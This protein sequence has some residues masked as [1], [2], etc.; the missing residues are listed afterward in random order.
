MIAAL[1]C[2]K[3]SADEGMWMIHMIDSALEKKMQERGL[4]LSARE[5]YNAD[6]PGASLSDAVVSME[7][8]CSGSFISDQGLVITN[9]HCAYS[10][11]HALST[12]EHN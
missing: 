3:M 12:Q 2:L 11:V 4:V 5:I 6:A 10:D 8:G 9:H 1:C 7:F